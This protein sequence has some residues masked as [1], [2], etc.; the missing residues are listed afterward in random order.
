MNSKR[1]KERVDKVWP[2]ALVSWNMSSSDD[3]LNVI[4]V[5]KLQFVISEVTVLTAQPCI[6]TGQDVPRAGSPRSQPQSHR[7]CWDR[8]SAGVLVQCPGISYLNLHRNHIGNVG[9][10]SLAGGPAQCPALVYLDLIC[11][12]GTVPRCKPTIQWKVVFQR[13]ASKSS[14]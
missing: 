4:A 14:W 2:P 6:I 1:V 5:Q 10:G 13:S 11:N 3:Y 8:E 9:T 12:A 7:W